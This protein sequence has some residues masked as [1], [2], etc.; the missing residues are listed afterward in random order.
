MQKR[1]L[2]AIWCAVKHDVVNHDSSGRKLLSLAARLAEEIDAEP[3][4]SL[5]DKAAYVWSVIEKRGFAELR[6]DVPP[7]LMSKS[8]F[9]QMLMPVAPLGGKQVA[10]L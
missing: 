9:E 3:Q 10:V 4:H 6:R 1:Y 8:M 2:H 5:K 7:R